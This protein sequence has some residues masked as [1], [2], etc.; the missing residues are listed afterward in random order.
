MQLPH[1]ITKADI[2]DLVESILGGAFWNEC[3]HW[4][5]DVEVKVANSL[6]P[7][8]E[9]STNDNRFTISVK[10]IDLV[11]TDDEML[12]WGFDAV[13]AIS[14]YAVTLDSAQAISDMTNTLEMWEAYGSIAQTIS[15]M[16]IYPE[17]YF[18]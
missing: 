9:V 2:K 11:S 18:E 13:V 12:G 7:H 1:D 15:E 16:E 8:I 6:Q 5:V 14:G 17:H 3:S 10:T 4:G